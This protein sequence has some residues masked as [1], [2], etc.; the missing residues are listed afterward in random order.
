MPL[1]SASSSSI[2][3]EEPLI[4]LIRDSVIGERSVISGPFGPRP[5]VYADYVASGRSLGFI[6]AAIE[7]IVLPVYG[8]TH[9]ETSHTGRQTTALREEARQTIASSVGAGE[10]HAV[11]FA[12]NGATTAVDCLVSAMALQELIQDGRQPVVFV[13]PYEHHSNDLPW[14]E[15][16]AT[17]ERVPLGSDG[18]IDLDALA[19]RLAAY[20]D[21]DLKIG[22][23]S[24]ASNVTGVRTDLVSIARLLHQNSAL[25]VC[26]FA[27]AAPYIE[28]KLQL[29]AEDP[30]ACI[31]AIVYS[32]HKFIGG[33]GA[34]GVLIADK[35]LFTNGRPGITGGG[36]VS[37]VTADHHTY[38]RDIERR[39]EAGTPDIIGDIRAGAVM[40]L[41][42]AVGALEIE[43]RE[44]AITNTAFD[45]LRAAPNIEILGPS[46]KERI[47]VLSFNIRIDGSRLHYGFVVALLND[48]FGIQARGGCSC[49]G[50]YAHALLDISL[51]DALKFE[52]AIGNGR[53]VMRPGWVRL[54]YNYF[55]DEETVD[56]ITDAILFVSEHGTRFLCDYEVD[57]KN[58][59]WKHRSSRPC[60]P[61]SLKA[62]WTCHGESR[63]AERLGVK[64]FLSVAQDLADQRALPCL[65]PAT[66]LNAEDE[67]MRAFWL[68]QDAL[69]FANGIRDG[70]G[71]AVDASSPP[72]ENH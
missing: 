34:S 70:V 52:K 44:Q 22:A 21:S 2:S 57:V 5:L 51:E 71:T 11:I 6:E 36:A 4:S 12:G 14:R 18:Q 61:A 62:F 63:V 30:D 27:A 25:F 41:K 13:G 53:G 48:L 38:V 3:P 17:I 65:K 59:N 60:A 26:D 9:T 32:S 37:Y 28:M 29:D 7:K 1:K 19:E 54:G 56:Y 40:A 20:S 68:P 10:N 50:P 39:E 69:E 42:E 15:T 31:D 24:A 23:F 72:Q 55:F 8:N 58:G 33:P 43:R 35:S 47:G 67:A 66:V 49:A 16:G 45:R 46:N 64:P